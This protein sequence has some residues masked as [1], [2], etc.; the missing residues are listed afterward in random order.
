[1]PY[2]LGKTCKQH[3]E[4]EIAKNVDFVMLKLRHLIKD[5]MMM[6]VMIKIV[7]IDIIF[8]VKKD[9]HV[10]INALVLMEKD[11][12]HLVLIKNVNNLLGN[13]DKQKMI[14]V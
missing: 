12:A 10:D 1:M 8:L 14:I 5:L 6:F 7:E 4:H 2:H 13:L 3:L 11:N 9:Y